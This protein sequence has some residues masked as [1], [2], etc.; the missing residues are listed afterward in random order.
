MFLPWLSDEQKAEIKAQKESGSEKI[1]D[2]ILEFFEVRDLQWFLKLCDASRQW[3]K[4]HD[5]RTS[6]LPRRRRRAPS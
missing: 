5:L 6:T 3:G 1:G 4:I 2:K